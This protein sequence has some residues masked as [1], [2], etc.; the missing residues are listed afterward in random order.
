MLLHCQLGIVPELQIWHHLLH[1]CET[2]ECL[3]WDIRGLSGLCYPASTPQ[4]ALSKG[5]A[6]VF[7][8]RAPLAALHSPCRTA[9]WSGDKQL[10][11][12]QTGSPQFCL[13][14]AVSHWPVFWSSG[15]YGTANSRENSCEKMQTHLLVTFSINTHLL[16]CFS[17]QPL[18]Q[19]WL[20]LNTNTTKGI[21][22]KLYC[23]AQ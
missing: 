10:H 2:S 1:P 7:T 20:L 16:F 15:A 8:S 5:C 9:R 22:Q 13:F 3:K 18:Q 23:W 14:P 17:C 6:Q 19:H 21:L 4:R 12:F 11:C